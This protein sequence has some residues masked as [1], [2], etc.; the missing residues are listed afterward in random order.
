LSFIDGLAGL[1]ITCAHVERVVEKIQAASQ[2]EPYQRVTWM[3][4]EE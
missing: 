2:G 1:D 3:N 4:L